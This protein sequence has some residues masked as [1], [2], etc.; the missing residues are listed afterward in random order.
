MLSVTTQFQK[1]YEISE[2]A[3]GC[4]KGAK[5]QGPEFFRVAKIFILL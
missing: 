1:D 3:L 4:V 2:A 5:L